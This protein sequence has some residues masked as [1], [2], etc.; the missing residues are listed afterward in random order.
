MIKKTTRATFTNGG[1]KGEYDW[2]GG[3]PLGIGEKITIM[4][5]A[6]TLV[7]QVTDKK[8]TLN[9]DGDTQQVTTEYFLELAV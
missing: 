8:T 1:Y 6:E 7:Y 9:E 4:R 3:I 2:K 5:G